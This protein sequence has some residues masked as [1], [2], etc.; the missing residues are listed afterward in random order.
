MQI[1]LIISNIVLGLT[2]LTLVFGPRLV[3]ILKKRKLKRETK[4][5]DKIRKIVEEY[6][7]ELRNDN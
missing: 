1:I 6:L 3:R 4:R 7:N 5:N 2:V